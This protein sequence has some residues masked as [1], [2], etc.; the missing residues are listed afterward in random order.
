M[1]YIELVTNKSYKLKFL[2]S[3]VGK[4]KYSL[5]TM[6]FYTKAP[7]LQKPYG[8]YGPHMDLAR[9]FQQMVFPVTG[10]LVMLATGMTLRM[11]FPN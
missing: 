4:Q 10:F 9:C 6:K 8:G 1:T 3:E 7:L 2:S 11:L 5:I